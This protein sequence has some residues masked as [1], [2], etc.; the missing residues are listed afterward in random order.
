MNILN[1]AIELERKKRGYASINE[2]VDMQ[3]SDGLAKLLSG[4]HGGLYQNQWDLLIGD[5][6]SKNGKP[7]TYTYTVNHDNGKGM[8]TVQYTIGQDRKPVKGSI[9]LAPN[10]QQTQAVAGVAVATSSQ[11]GI[12]EKVLR[13]LRASLKAN[14]NKTNTDEAS[15]ASVIEAILY[16]AASNSFNANQLQKLI[17][18]VFSSNESDEFVKVFNDTWGSTDGGAGNTLAKAFLNLGSVSIAN[19]ENDS[20]CKEVVSIVGSNP[21]MASTNIT[22]ADSISKLA[23]AIFDILSDYSVTQDEEL[24]VMMGILSL[25]TQSLYRLVNE[26]NSIHKENADNKSL[27]QYVSSELDD[28]DTRLIFNAMYRGIAKAP[29]AK[30]KALLTEPK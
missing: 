24:I 10:V 18:T 23:Q 28:V 5:Y 22:K 21:K 26:W 7:G 4:Q 27:D 30:A 29:S 19:L 8:I 6:E 14:L 2:A 9:K 11:V 15:V 1:Y 25:N 13:K 16:Y 20:A 12:S 3:N 17:T